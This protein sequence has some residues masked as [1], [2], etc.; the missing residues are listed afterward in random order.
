MRGI[1]FDSKNNVIYFYEVNEEVLYAAKTDGTSVSKII[2]GSYGYS[3]F[4]DEV[5]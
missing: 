1:A 3:L 2:E 5:N 4:V